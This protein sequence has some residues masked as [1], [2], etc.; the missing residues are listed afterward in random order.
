MAQAVKCG[1]CGAVMQGRTYA[2]LR[3]CPFCGCEISSIP[4]IMEFNEAV[5]QRMVKEKTE[6]DRRETKKTVTVIVCCL[7]V[8]FAIILHTIMVTRIPEQKL[9]A[10]VSEIQADI[11]AEQYD[12][13]MTK[14]ALL[15]YDRSLSDKT[16]DKWDRIREDLVKQI[17]Q[18]QGH[19]WFW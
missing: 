19:W 17:R 10:I 16:A 6:E 12:E 11:Q 2:G 8:I 15:H 18:K 3:V 14:T 13:A 4:P 9:E 7:I 5:R 1:Q